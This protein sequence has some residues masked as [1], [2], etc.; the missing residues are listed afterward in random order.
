MKKRIY[1]LAL[2]AAT[3]AAITACGK[4]DDA[5]NAP[6]EQE[7]EA[8]TPS[9]DTTEPEDNET[10]TPTETPSDAASETQTPSP[11]PD[12]TPDPSL[13]ES[14]IPPE[15][16]LPTTGSASG[17]FVGF[18]DSHTV[19]VILDDGETISYQVKKDSVLAALEEMDESGETALSFKYKI[20]ADGDYI[21]T[22][23]K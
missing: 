12:T 11:G 20:T 21:I 18:V 23:V 10:D 15:Q 16:N 3:C 5:T 22:K 17:T 4:K 6:S 14:T 19:E 9:D 13:A 7:T 8:A 1:I 2:I